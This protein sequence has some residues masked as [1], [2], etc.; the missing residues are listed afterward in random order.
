M[1]A[2]TITWYKHTSA[3]HTAGSSITALT[4]GT[5]TAGEWSPLYCVSCMA[6][7]NDAEDVKFW[8]YD[9]VATLSGGGNVSLG[10]SGRAWAM[11]A[12][13]TASLTGTT[14]LF[15]STGSLLSA[16]E[17]L[18]TDY[19]GSPND[20]LGAG[21]S[22]GTVTSGNKILASTRSLY[23]FLG[24]KPTA[25]AYDGTYSDFAYQIGYDFS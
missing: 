16:A 21:M 24:V 19:A 8:L 7:T 5:V 17:A 12:R 10:E 14:T 20:S 18:A 13:T 23:L 9:S 4:M 11:R 6:A 22:L 15:S 2:P 25:T 3:G 1:A